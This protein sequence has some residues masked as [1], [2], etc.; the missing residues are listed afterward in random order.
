MKNEGIS[1]MPCLFI[2][3]ILFVV[4]CFIVDF[5]VVYK[6]RNELVRHMENVVDL[7]NNNEINRLKPYSDEHSF[8][9]EYYKE[10]NK[11]KFIVTKDIKLL[12]PVPKLIFGDF[13]KIE[14]TKSINI[15]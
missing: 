11:V 1:I 4:G 7:Y 15:E 3:P 12:T 10:E 5:M 14:L 6:Q 13:Y 8:K 2:I 9:L